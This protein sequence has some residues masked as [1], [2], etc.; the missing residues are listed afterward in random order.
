M[1]SGF[2]F[3]LANPEFCSHL[4]SWRVVIRTPVVTFKSEYGFTLLEKK[5]SSQKKK[6]KI[7]FELRQYH[8]D[9]DA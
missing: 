9:L 5:N 1:A 4:A 6:K 8:I 7:A 3:L 2:V